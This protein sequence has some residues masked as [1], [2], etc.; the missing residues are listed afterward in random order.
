MKGS[1]NRIV[2][3]NKIKRRQLWIRSIC[4]LSVIF[5]AIILL[6]IP[7]K[8]ISTAVPTPEDGKGHF[9]IKISDKITEGETVDFN[10]LFFEDMGEDVQPWSG[11]YK[12]R[13]DK[14]NGEK[15]EGDLVGDT[16]DFNGESLGY[17]FKGL[18]KGDVVTIFNVENIKFSKNVTAKVIITSSNKNKFAFS[19]VEKINIASGEINSIEVNYVEDSEKGISDGNNK[20]FTSTTT[21]KDL[22]GEYS[23]VNILNR[24]NVFSF[25]DVE[26]VH[27]YGTVAANNEAYYRREYG[28]KEYASNSLAFSE[29][30]LGV[31][32]F[33]RNV[34]KLKNVDEATYKLNYGSN[35]TPKPE[36]EDLYIGSKTKVT[37]ERKGYE[38]KFYF[39]NESGKFIS[40]NANGDKEV[41]INDNF[42]NFNEVKSEIEKESKLLLNNKN[43]IVLR[44]ENGLLV[45]PELG[46]NYLVEDSDKVRVVNI[47][48]PKEYDPRTNPYPY[49]T[50]ITMSG[51]LPK[52]GS[53]FGAIDELGYLPEI[54]YPQI[55]V[56]GIKEKFQYFPNIYV[57]DK[58]FNGNFAGQYGEYGKS[59]GVIWNMP[60]VKTSDGK[61]TTQVESDILGHI[62]AP[63]AIFWNAKNYD[64]V[65]S[66]WKGGNI[67]GSVIVES[68]HGG[69]MESHV[70]PVGD[71]DIIPHK[72]VEFNFTGKKNYIDGNLKQ[73]EFS[74]ILELF[75]KSSG[76]PDGI[77]DKNLNQ[78]IDVDE[79]GNIK[80]LPLT[81]TKPGIYEFRIKEDISNE[82]IDVTYDNT[83]YKLVVTV[84]EEANKEL[85]ASYEIFKVIDRDGNVV[86]QENKVGEVIFTNYKDKPSVVNLEFLKIDSIDKNKVLKGAVFELIE[87]VSATDHTETSNKFTAVSDESGRISFNNIPSDKVYKLVETNAPEGYKIPN[88][89][90]IVEVSGIGDGKQIKITKSNENMPT[91][92][93]SLMI[94]NDILDYILPETGGRGIINITLIGFAFIIVSTL[95]LKN[96]K[97]IKSGG[98]N[99]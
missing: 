84:N 51:G 66:D 25:K 93:E 64:E 12:Y 53:K 46:K 10:V 68:W 75:D 3:Q 82:M 96:K 85:V 31:S 47:K 30:P 60:N 16:S 19:P 54:T 52:S 4:S 48:Y 67:N 49:P 2:I 72:E 92:N 11:V 34:K 8:T 57:N 29:Y 15:I 74:F 43:N 32:S 13:I 83:Q 77:A 37:K 33:V 95:I 94:P 1:L 97:Y 86:T 73:G 61:V 56:F 18:Y 20:D 17:S 88:G 9:Q 45:I 23:I 26:C 38:E 58:P 76:I 50:V 27:I 22:Y 44:P 6:K 90:W 91:I 42:I 24:Y 98:V 5:L 36:P 71:F 59:N 55:H 80:F 35:S 21:F 99:K 87:I 39:T 7:A 14:A 28:S 81:F 41:Y 40:P 78:K 70:W 63:N 65:N 79:N 69:K 89:Y 62:V